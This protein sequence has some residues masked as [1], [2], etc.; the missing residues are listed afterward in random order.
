MDLRE[1]ESKGT[2][3]GR[4]EKDADGEE[5]LSAQESQKMGSTEVTLTPMM[6][7]WPVLA[8]LC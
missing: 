2:L 3:L 6:R 4:H 8:V 1:K 5:E 7:S